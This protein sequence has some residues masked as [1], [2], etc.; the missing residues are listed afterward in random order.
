[1]IA[2]V[3]M[4][5]VSCL[6]SLLTLQC[7]HL[8]LCVHIIILGVLSIGLI[9]GAAVIIVLSTVITIIVAITCSLVKRKAPIC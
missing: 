8:S 1:M 6:L 4:Q 7:S 2:K 9:S 5:L 3:I